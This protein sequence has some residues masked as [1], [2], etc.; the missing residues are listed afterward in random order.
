MNSS[1]LG[2][3]SALAS[4]FFSC[5]VFLISADAD[6]AS[7]LLDSSFLSA[8]DNDSDDTSS[9]LVSFLV[10]VLS[11]FF[12]SD[13]SSNSTDFSSDESFS[14]DLTN[15]F[16][17][18]TV[19]VF[20]TGVDSITFDAS[21]SV[22]LTLIS[23]NFSS[24]LILISDDDFSV[25]NVIGSSIL[26]S[27]FFSNSV[28]IDSFGAITDAVSDSNGKLVS[29]FLTCSDL[30]SSVGFSGCETSAIVA[31]SGVS[32]AGAAFAAATAAGSDDDTD[33]TCSTGPSVPRVTLSVGIIF[34]FSGFSGSATAAG[35]AAGDEA[36]SASLISD[37][38][39]ILGISTDWDSDAAVA[40][41]TV[42]STGA[43]AIDAGFSAS[44]TTGDDFTSPDETTGASSDFAIAVLTAGTVA[45]VSTGFSSIGCCSG[46]ASTLTAAIGSALL[47]WGT[48]ASLKTI[49]KNKKYHKKYPFFFLN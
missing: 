2:S 28:A 45:T 17:G 5:L 23:S 34:F 14:T 40:S 29:V 9:A 3:S 41:D 12:S 25:G 15:S 37:L 26:I 38:A 48:T 11:S 30:I 19:S 47:T 8:W 36:T 27:S 16:F 13:L 42:D 7:A 18:S 22:D 39:E 35:D 10:S 32:G 46:F 33:D 43:D 21:G 31:I 1:G 4:I 6:D 20:T 44:V 24:V 49:K